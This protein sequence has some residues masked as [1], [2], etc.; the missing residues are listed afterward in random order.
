MR[1]AEADERMVRLMWKSMLAAL[2][3]LAL[4]MGSIAVLLLWPS[5]PPMFWIFVVGCPAVGMLTGY[6]FMRCS[7]ATRSP[8]AAL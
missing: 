8:S 7:A 5:D 4:M 2:A 1:H 6:M 3:I